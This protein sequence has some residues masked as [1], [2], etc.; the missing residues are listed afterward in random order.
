MAKPLRFRVSREQWSDDRVRRDILQPL[1]ANIGARSVSLRASIPAAYTAFRF[2]M[3]N[4]D[5]AVFAFDDEA[6]YWMGN[7]ETPRALWRTDKY[8][9]DAVPYPVSRWAQREFLD[10]L[11]ERASWLAEY[12]HLSW[13]F[14]PV[15]MSKDGRHSTRRFFRE[16][17]AGFPDT[18]WQTAADVLE[19]L[20]HPGFLDPYREVMAGKLGTSEHVDRTRMSAAVSE[21]LAADL[22]FRADYDVRPEVEVS[23]GHAIDFRASDDTHTTLVEVTR[24]TNPRRR[25]ASGAVAAIKDTIETKTSGQL[26]EHGG[27]IVLFVDCSGFDD[28]QWEAILKHRPEVGHRPTVVYRVRPGAPTRGYRLGRVPLE[29]SDVIEF[30]T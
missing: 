24:P 26:S 17:A 20:L 10:T 11:H 4:G 27:G 28:A 9:W 30:D 2:E 16:Y 18:D 5:L 22:L 14:L 8:S 25:S 12:P 23:T 6:G 3:T 21:F 19:T 15:F 7:T 29:L 1:Q 13:F